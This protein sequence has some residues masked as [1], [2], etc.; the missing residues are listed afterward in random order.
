MKISDNRSRLMNNESTNEETSR[1]RKCYYK[2]IS[3][4]FLRKILDINNDL[5]KNLEKFD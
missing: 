3:K 2:K 1:P 5:E 4:E